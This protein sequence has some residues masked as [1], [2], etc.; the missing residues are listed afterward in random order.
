M[1]N[2]NLIK[3]PNWKATLAQFNKGDV[4][5]YKVDA[6]EIAKL[7]QVISRIR[8]SQGKI[9]TTNSLLGGG[10]EIKRVI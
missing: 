1:V 3:S 9:F 10:I 6:N 7:R 8:K 4:F 5:Q 2:G